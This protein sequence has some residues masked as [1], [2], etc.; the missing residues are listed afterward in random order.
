MLQ[1]SKNVFICTDSHFSTS[2]LIYITKVNSHIYIALPSS[3]TFIN[4]LIHQ[5]GT[6]RAHSVLQGLQYIPVLHY[7]LFTPLSFALYKP[8]LLNVSICSFCLILAFVEGI[9]CTTPTSVTCYL[10]R[11]IYTE[12]RHS[13]IACGWSV[14]VFVFSY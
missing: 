6:N 5:K 10:L 7:Y 11:K 4:I 9:Y 8:D 2:K 3:T 14:C 13:E 12:K 1:H